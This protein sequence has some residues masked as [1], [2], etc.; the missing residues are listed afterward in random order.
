M[1]D[2]AKFYKNLDGR[3]DLQRQVIIYKTHT[4]TL[5]QIR[6]QV[7]LLDGLLLAKSV[8]TDLLAKGGNDAD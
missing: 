2:L 6:Y 4:E 7:G 8:I 3:I 1:L 5:D